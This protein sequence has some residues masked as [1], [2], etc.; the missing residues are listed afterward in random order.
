MTT[1]LFSID[2]ILDK[3][4]G[5]I[6]TADIP[7]GTLIHSE[8]PLF[9]VPPYR[10]PMS[11][12]DFNHTIIEVLQCLNDS[13]R[14]TFLGLAR[15][16]RNPFQFVDIVRTNA[17]PLGVGSTRA[18]IFPTAARLNHACTANAVYSWHKGEEKV[19]V[20]AIKDIKQ[21][22]EITAD[23]TRNDVWANVRAARVRM[24]LDQFSFTCRCEV[25]N[26][27]GVEQVNSSMRR[28]EF[29]RLCKALQKGEKNPGKALG[30]CRDMLRI[31]EDEGEQDMKVGAVFKAAFERCVDCGDL[32]RARAFMGMNVKRKIV[33]LG[34]DYPDL[35]DDLILLGSPQ[36][37]R[38]SSAT[39]RW[40]TRVGDAKSEAGNGFEEWLWARAEWQ[41]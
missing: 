6:A 31:L 1:P 14:A 24:I 37:W 21:G 23:Y 33:C 8:H 9:I 11:D 40:A 38:G 7:K 30:Y 22:D 17:M 26:L 13:E 5:L 35:D 36:N 19:R 32:A 12:S 10:P 16:F 3:G 2:S 15:S 25:C 34:P 28:S 20:F 18:G 4:N 39:D 29:G 27:T 41:T